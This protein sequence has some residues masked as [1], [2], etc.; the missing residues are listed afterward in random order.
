[1]PKQTLELFNQDGITIQA[2]CHLVENAT[3]A[4]L[5]LHGGGLIFGERDDL[6][7]PYIT[8]FNQAGYSFIT[9]DYPLA[10]ETKLDQTLRILNQS[11]GT[12]STELKLTDTVAMGRSAGSYL[13]YLLIKDGFSPRAFLD[14]YGYANVTDPSFKMPAPAYTK[15]PLVAPME[16]R[17]LIQKH[18]VVNADLDQRFPLYLSGRQL[19]TWLSSFLPR[20]N[21]AAQFSVAPAEL[22]AFPPTVLVHCSADPDVPYALAK[23]SAD[24]IPRSELLTLNLAEH[25]FD[26][27]VSEESLRVYDQFIDWLKIE[28]ANL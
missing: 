27:A 22:A 7:E 11:L 24:L 9:L 4:I 21:Q 17:A 19:G 12:L 6:P 14:F 13:W 1:M 2:T 18:P 8:K 20:V 23:A 3:A 16:A 26:R 15:F 25:D 28:F 10:P 5:Y